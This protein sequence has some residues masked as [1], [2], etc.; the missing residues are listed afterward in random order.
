[1]KK[2]AKSRL[3][4]WFMHFSH[5]SKQK[6]I[7]SKAMRHLQVS[8]AIAIWISKMWSKQF[9]ELCENIKWLVVRLSLDGVIFQNGKFYL[10][11]VSFRKSLS[12]KS[13]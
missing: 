4:D 10:K 8:V 13:Q 7:D 11:N 2:V 6:L 3:L 5:G 9:I 1:M 12:E